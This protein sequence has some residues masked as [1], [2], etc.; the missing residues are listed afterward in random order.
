MHPIVELDS[1][2]FSP[3]QRAVAF[4]DVAAQMCLLDVTPDP[5]I[6]FASTIRLY[7]LPDLQISRTTW[8]AS[9]TVRTS[10]HT[11]ATGDH[12]I[13][14]FPL[15]GQFSIRQTGGEECICRP[16]EV[17]V[18]PTAERGIDIF[19]SPRTDLIYLSTPRAR[20]KDLCPQ[21]SSRFRQKQ[22]LTGPWKLLLSYVQTLT[23]PALQL[24]DREH[25]QCSQHLVD[26]LAMLTCP[27]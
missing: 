16:G 27:H 21:L 2:D 26:L 22:K 17:Y 7:L 23:D 3:A 20:L 18:D 1:R 14:H 8:T 15:T 10:S 6:E 24:S 5:D 13:F 4:R 12:V 25:S 11:Y 9:T 19:Q